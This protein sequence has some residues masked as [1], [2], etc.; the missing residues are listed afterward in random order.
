MDRG[1]L[2]QLYL[3]AIEALGSFGGAEAIDALKV[4]LRTGSWWTIL[5]NRKYGGAAAHALRRIGTPG[6]MEA[7]REA[8][9]NGAPGARGAARAELAGPG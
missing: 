7:L 3:T 8:S 4:A 6:A 1:Q 5:A 9:A 2:P